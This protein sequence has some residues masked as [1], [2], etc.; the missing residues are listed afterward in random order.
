MLGI[1]ESE[2]RD[3]LGDPSQGP[4]DLTAAAKKL[5]VSED[6]LQEALG[7]PEHG[8]RPR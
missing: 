1:E 5:G 4:P 6:E 3:A 7:L 8:G 2:L